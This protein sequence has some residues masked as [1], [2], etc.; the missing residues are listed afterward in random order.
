M[1]APTV[2]GSCAVVQVVG[3]SPGFSTINISYQTSEGKLEASTLVGAY[4]Y[5]PHNCFQGPV[6]TKFGDIDFP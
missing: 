6:M 1:L 3:K 4:R 5:S 2:S